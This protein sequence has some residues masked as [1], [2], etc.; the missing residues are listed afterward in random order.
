MKWKGKG[1]KWRIRLSKRQK[2]RR[3]ERRI[4]G[5][6]QRKRWRKKRERKKDK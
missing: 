5:S 2:I 3:E 1:M 6:N 4:E